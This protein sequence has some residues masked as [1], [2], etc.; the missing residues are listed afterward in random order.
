MLLRLIIVDLRAQT[1]RV[2]S[3]LVIKGLL[4]EEAYDHRLGDETNE[5]AGRVQD[6]EAIVVR[7]ESC[8]ARGHVRDA[9]QS[10]DFIDHD[11]FCLEV[12]G[13]LGRMLSQERQL[14]HAH[15]TIIK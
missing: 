2:Q 11:I 5:S 8:P 15:G 12:L 14:L 7:L 9:R 1:A 13:G 3:I 6:R 10:D 4:F